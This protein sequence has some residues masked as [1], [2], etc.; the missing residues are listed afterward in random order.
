M[1]REIASCKVSKLP[2]ADTVEETCDPQSSVSRIL[3]PLGPTAEIEEDALLE[4]PSES[5]ASRGMSMHEFL[6]RGCKCTG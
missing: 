6:Q 4:D 1:T 3:V 5:N 2:E